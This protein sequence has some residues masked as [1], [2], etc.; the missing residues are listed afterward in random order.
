MLKQLSLIII[1]LLSL[2][3]CEREDH[4]SPDYGQEKLLPDRDDYLNE[5]YG[6]QTFAK[7][8]SGIYASEIGLIYYDDETRTIP[9]LYL[10]RGE[11]DIH[12]DSLASGA[13]NVYFNKFNTAFMPLQLS[14]KIKCLLEA[15]V[16]TI[17]IRGSDGIVRTSNDDGPIGAPLPE[18][19]D[20]ELIGKYARKTG[21]IELFID[22]MLPVPVKASVKGKKG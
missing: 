5:D 12:I 2:P 14:V 19:D 4:L 22:P 9:Q 18:S 17:Y 8:L 21:M 13:V 3:G 15:T 7:E 10:T 1:I 16:D 6:T 20:A 11:K